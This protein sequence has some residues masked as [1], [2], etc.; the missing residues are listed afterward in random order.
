M[1]EQTPAGGAAKPASRPGRSA[2]L[3]AGERG[4]GCG[5]ARGVGGEAQ[6]WRGDQAHGTGS[7]FREKHSCPRA[8]RGD[9]PVRADR[10]P[11][12]ATASAKAR[13]RGEAGGA[14]CPGE[15]PQAG[16]PRGRSV[17]GSQCDAS[18]PAEGTAGTRPPREAFGS[19]VGG[20]G[21]WSLLFLEGVCVCEC[22][23]VCVNARVCV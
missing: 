8:Q 12:L 21:L 1:G 20:R 2:G 16:S 18:V 5:G 22:T 4:G 14:R 3:P 17:A 9:A 19:T 15:R 11:E 23:C 6:G 13:G 10:Y 7:R